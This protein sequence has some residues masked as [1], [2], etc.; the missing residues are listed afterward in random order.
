M[1]FYG[2]NVGMH[3]FYKALI[4]ILS[5]WLLTFILSH[6]A[7]LVRPDYAIIKFVLCTYQLKACAFIAKNKLI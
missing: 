3:C 1:S 5:L 4:L 7:S 6:S 2:M